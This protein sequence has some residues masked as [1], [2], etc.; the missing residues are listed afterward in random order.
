VQDVMSSSVQSITTLQ[1][2]P[3]EAEQEQVARGQRQQRAHMES[4]AENGI[5]QE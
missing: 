3:D 2:S 5:F 1:N 4:Y